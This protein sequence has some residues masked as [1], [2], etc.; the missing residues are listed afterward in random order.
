MEGRMVATFPHSTNRLSTYVLT[1]TPQIVSSPHLSL[2]VR[3]DHRFLKSLGI[4]FSPFASSPKTHK[5]VE[6]PSP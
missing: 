2:T 6:P 4:S 3:F 5:L 1:S